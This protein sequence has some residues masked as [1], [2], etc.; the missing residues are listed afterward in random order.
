M[1]E[2]GHSEEFDRLKKEQ[3]D[4]IARDIAEI[5]E[6]M[7]RTERHIGKM[8]EEFAR[9]EQ[10]TSIDERVRKIEVG[11]GKLIGMCLA[12]QLFGGGLIAVLTLLKKQP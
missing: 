7:I 8:R 1:S 4:R 5:R 2:A 6:G 12:I 10:V 9:A 3:Q 11:W